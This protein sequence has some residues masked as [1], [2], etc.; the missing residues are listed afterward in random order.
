MVEEATTLEVV[1]GATTALNS[2]VFEKPGLAPE[3][4]RELTA[5]LGGLRASGGESA[6]DRIGA[7]VLAARDIDIDL[8]A[9]GLERLGPDAKKITV[10]SST[11]DRALAVSSRL[12]GGIIRARAADRERLESLG[13]RVADASEFG[14]GIINHDLFLTNKEVQQVIKR[15]IERS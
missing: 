10:I 9:R 3:Q 5:L 12:A 4:V 14:G 13:V 1:E 8:F 11:N 6:M 7:V 15:A 2:E